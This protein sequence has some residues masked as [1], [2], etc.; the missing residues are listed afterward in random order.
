MDW[1]A[2]LHLTIASPYS[3]RAMYRDRLP[4]GESA[5]ALVKPLTTSFESN[6]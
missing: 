2:Q 6:G 3:K 4:R 1:L 5:W